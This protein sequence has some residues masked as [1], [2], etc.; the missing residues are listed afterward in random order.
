MKKIFFYENS[1]MKPFRPLRAI[2]VTV[3]ILKLTF[4][5]YY[6]AR[7]SDGKKGD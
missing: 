7:S 2:N 1:L 6:L 3:D 5:A 4:I